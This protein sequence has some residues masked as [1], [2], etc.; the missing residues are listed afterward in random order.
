MPNDANPHRAALYAAAFDSVQAD[1]DLLRAV[2]A[3]EAARVEVARADAALDAARKR[4]D[5][6]IDAVD[7]KNK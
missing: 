7:A 2:A 6:A 5:A 1:N 4:F 3:L